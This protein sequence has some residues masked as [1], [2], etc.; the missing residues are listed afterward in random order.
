M[1]QRILFTMALFMLFAAPAVYGQ[2]SPE[3]VQQKVTQ[4]IGVEAAAQAKADDWSWDKQGMISKIRDAKYR[5]TWLKYR[6]EKNRQYIAKAKQNIADLEYQKE[7]LNKLREQLEPYLEGVILRLQDFVNQDL[8]FLPE[9]RAKRIAALK[10]SM[11]N[12]DL[13]LSE[14]FRRV[15]EEG[16][17]IETEYGK[18]VDG[19]VETTLNINGVDT[20][21]T[22]FRL[23]RV[24]MY[25][26]SL[27]E[28]QSGYYNRTTGKWE[29]LPEDMNQEIKLAIDISGAKRSVQIV[30][31]PLGA[32]K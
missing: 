2:Q 7:E 28:T 14:K 25:Y 9:E 10:T 3:K 19:S 17:E 5:V 16:L 1:I 27:D 21:V 11:D 30:N 8:P 29:P 22:I 15:F 31:L 26:L 12:Y 4:A 24:G 18:V 6:Q 32:V 13:P 23:G 20:Q